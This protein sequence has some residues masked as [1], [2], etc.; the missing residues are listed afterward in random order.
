[1]CPARAM[2]SPISGIPG[3]E[4]LVMGASGIQ[5]DAGPSPLPANGGEGTWWGVDGTQAKCTRLH[6]SPQPRQEGLYNYPT[7][8]N[9]EVGRDASS[10]GNSNR[11][12][13][14]RYF[15]AQR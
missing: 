3:N 5:G 2:R 13:V 15:P 11:S 7:A 6:L 14:E 4:G 9:S 1:M 8:S 12:S 10:S